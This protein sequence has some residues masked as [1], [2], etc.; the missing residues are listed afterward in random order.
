M[1]DRRMIVMSG[2][3]LVAVVKLGASDHAPGMALNLYAPNPRT[4]T[5]TLS[6]DVAEN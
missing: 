2:F 4:M 3:L 1:G 5:M 6:R